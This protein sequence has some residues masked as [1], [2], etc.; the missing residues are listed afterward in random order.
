MMGG[1][2][3]RKINEKLSILVSTERLFERLDKIE[4]TD[5][6]F[7]RHSILVGILLLCACL[8]IN[9]KLWLAFQ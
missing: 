5:D 2:T 7:Y 4:K 1:K 3:I 8:L 9:I 6:W